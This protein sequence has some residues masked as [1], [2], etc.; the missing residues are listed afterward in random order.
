MDTKMT[1]YKNSLY[2]ELSRLTKGLG[3]EKRLEILNLLTQ[4]PKPVEGIS[5]ATGLSV[6]NTSRH[7][8]V[9]KES[10]LVV[11]SRQG[12][13]IRYSLASAKVAQ[14]ILFLF[15]IGE[16]QLAEV[17]TIEAEYDR[18]AGVN[19]ISLQEAVELSEQPD[20]LLL[21]LRPVEEFEAGHLPRAVSLPMADFHQ[22]K[23]QLPKDRTIIVYC[24]GRQCGYA[25][26][27][28]QDLQSLGYPTF[29]LNRS[30]ADWKWGKREEC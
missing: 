27:A 5:L 3:S 22:K 26:V 28:A 21:D 16:E 23:T 12:N 18:E 14:L 10:N 2:K 19:Q 29:S 1:D 17:R 24:R 7:L 20:V 8:Q 15:D 11:T 6:A 30:F 13:F 9:L 25:N 4:G